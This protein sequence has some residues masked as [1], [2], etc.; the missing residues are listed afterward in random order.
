MKDMPS[1]TKD[2]IL[3]VAID[4]FGSKGEVT[5]R[6]ITE[7]AGVN[8][9]S[10]NYHFGSKN[11]LL[12]EVEEYYSEI[13]YNMQ[14]E[15]INNLECNPKEKL[16]YWANSLI[17]FMLKY[18]ALIT[19]VSDLVSKD[20]HYNPGL[21]KKFFFNLDLKE[22]IEEIISEITE[23]EDKK[24]LNLRYTQIFS[25]ILGP[26]LFQTITNVYSSER[27]FYDINNYEER[28]IYIEE[29]IN[30]ITIK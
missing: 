5:T 2:K 8:I 13:L 20:I 14:N 21:L 18:P 1:N 22:K 17:E 28:M 4:I 30:S 24:I 3:I 27:V 6:E 19:L 15:I 9:A 23:I 12:K 29:L 7:I 10:I 11:N 16:I 25:G 26:I